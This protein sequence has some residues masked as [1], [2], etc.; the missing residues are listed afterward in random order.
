MFFS[1]IIGQ[2]GAKDF[3]THA[4]SRQRIPHS[5][6]FT[7]I[8]GIGKTSAAGALTVALNCRE[9][10]N[11]DGCGQ[12]PVCH[13]IQ[14]G[15]FPD[16]LSV[17]P[18]GQT[19]RIEQIRELNRTLGFPPVSWGYRVSVIHQAVTMTREA[20]NAFLKTL[21]EPP[22]QNI[23]VLTTTEP[24]DLLPTIVS[25]CQRV[26][27][28]PLP[29]AEM[30]QWLIRE[31]GL[32]R[33]SAAMVARVSEGS[34]GVALKMLESDFL[35]R[36]VEWLSNV[37]RLFKVSKAEAL[38]MAFTSTDGKNRWGLRASDT[39]ETGLMD[40]LDTW[41]TW[42]RDMLLIRTGG[43]ERLIINTDFTDQIEA[44]AADIETDALIESLFTLDRA[45]ND[46][47]RM[48]SPAL[49]MENAVLYLK[50]MAESA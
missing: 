27:F 21:E 50:L 22:P 20:A 44:L 1:R 42:F 29:A 13:Q 24:H 23:L 3:L 12:C 10:V 45:Q 28:Q 8:P 35:D 39:P 6:M 17:K 48:R 2:A 30:A 38:E 36:R 34:L 40:M 16:F 18:D 37:R 11:F 33:G 4:I 41:E 47:R 7:G 5:Y 43:P 31:K 32:D 15:N 19:I 26:A 9:P 14:G 25:R 46:L 49:V